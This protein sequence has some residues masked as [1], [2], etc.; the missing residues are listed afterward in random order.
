MPRK[1]MKAPVYKMVSRR[2]L[3]GKKIKKAK[4]FSPHKNMIKKKPKS[5][6]IIHK[7]KK[8]LVLNPYKKLSAIV[9]KQ[10][11]PTDSSVVKSTEKGFRANDK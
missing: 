9:K 4:R 1:S 8:T 11:T 10:R 6:K 3:V 5:A 2:G 7:V